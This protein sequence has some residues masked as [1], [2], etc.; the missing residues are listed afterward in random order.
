MPRKRGRYTTADKKRVFLEIVEH[1][2]SHPDEHFDITI[3]G[4]MM[5]EK[6][7]GNNAYIQFKQFC[8][9]PLNA[10]T[11]P[12]PH[13]PLTTNKSLFQQ[14]ILRPGTFAFIVVLVFTLK[15][16]QKKTQLK[17]LYALNV[18]SKIAK[19]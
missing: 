12:P 11:P 8:G 13:P 9:P 4:K 7:S 6:L 17:A 18:N 5:D 19:F 10:S 15:I 1:I 3:Q 14:K 2:D 16:L